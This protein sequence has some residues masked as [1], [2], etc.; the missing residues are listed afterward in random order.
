MCENSKKKKK[1][2]N[3]FFFEIGKFFFFKLGKK[4]PKSHWEGSV[5]RYSGRTRRVNSPYM[6]VERPTLRCLQEC[7]TLNTLGILQFQRQK[8]LS[9][10]SA[11]VSGRFWAFLRRENTAGCPKM[12]VQTSP[13]FPI[14]PRT[15]AGKTR[16]VSMFWLSA[17]DN[18]QHR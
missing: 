10:C 13:D 17:C 4:S 5:H 6:L 7:K 16:D 14:F 9:N 3:F 18:F 12:T 8:K 1:K 15:P 11:S 2:K